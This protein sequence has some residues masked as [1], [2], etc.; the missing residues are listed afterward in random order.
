MCRLSNFGQYESTALID[1]AGR[2]SPLRPVPCVIGFFTWRAFSTI[3]IQRPVAREL[4]VEAKHQEKAITADAPSTEVSG[5][6]RFVPRSPRNFQAGRTAPQT[7]ALVFPA[8]TA[9]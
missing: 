1:A 5:L 3:T 4:Q 7:T 8:V 6:T 2:T 9:L